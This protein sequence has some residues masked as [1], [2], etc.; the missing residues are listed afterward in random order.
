MERS[1]EHPLGEA[2]VRGAQERRSEIPAAVEFDSVPGHGVRARVAGHDILL[3]NLNFLR[4]L[5]IYPGTLVRR[6]QEGG[7]TV[8]RIRDDSGCRRGRHHGSNEAE[9][10]LRNKGW[11]MMPSRMSRKPGTKVPTRAHGPNSA[12]T[13]GPAA[14]KYTG[15]MTRA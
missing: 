9:K 1:S 7:R 5:D 13:S 2:I 8:G 14:E 4:A 10:K 11:A 12:A 15:A 3:G 6:Q